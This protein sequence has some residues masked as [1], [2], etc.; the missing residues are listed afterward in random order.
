MDDGN[1]GGIIGLFLHRIML[2]YG[3][4]GIFIES[5]S[6]W[7]VFAHEISVKRL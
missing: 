2:I 3:C 6:H 4:G 7:W 5:T 1:D